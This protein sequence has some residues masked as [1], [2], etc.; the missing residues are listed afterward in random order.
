MT[1]VTPDPLMSAYPPPPRSFFSALRYCKNPL[2]VRHHFVERTN[3]RKFVAAITGVGE[4]AVQRVIDEIEQ[5]YDFHRLIMGKRQQFLGKA[6]HGTDWMYLVQEW[7]SQYFPFFIHYSMVRLLK[8]EIV[9]ETGGTPGSSSAFMLRAMERNGN[10]KVVTLDL[11]SLA[12]MG[13]IKTEPEKIWYSNM[14]KDLPPGWIVPD[15]LKARHEQ[16]LG[17]ARETLP[18]VMAQYPQ[19]DIFIHDSDH[20]YDHMMWEYKQAWP[21]I[22]AGGVLYSDDVSLHPVFDDFAREVGLPTIRYDNFGAIKKPL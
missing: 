22:K 20:S 7:G 9:V 13:E 12:M 4:D 14:P 8:P 18:N 3:R 5:D 19:V 1:L 10:G 17:D 6:P 11:P 16:V 15:T 21:N 2:L